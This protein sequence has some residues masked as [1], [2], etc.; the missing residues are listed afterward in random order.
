MKSFS[1]A[2]IKCTENYAQPTIRTNPNYLVT[3]VGTNDLSS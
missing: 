1:G 3:H 2:K